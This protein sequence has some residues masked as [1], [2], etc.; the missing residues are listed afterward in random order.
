MTEPWNCAEPMMVADV[1]FG[2]FH[3]RFG[4]S[5]VSWSPAA[6]LPL[7]VLITGVSPSMLTTTVAPAGMLLNSMPTTLVVEPMLPGTSNT[8]NALVPSPVNVTVEGD[9]DTV[10]LA[11]V[12]AAHFERLSNSATRDR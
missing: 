3:S 9:T 5:V 10:P 2:K 11:A 7:Y 4:R 8:C 12:S 1:A 6:P